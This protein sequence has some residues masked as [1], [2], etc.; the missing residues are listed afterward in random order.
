MYDPGYEGEVVD[1][2]LY[3]RTDFLSEAELKHARA[4]YAAEVTLVDRQVGRLLEKIEDLGLLANTLVMLTTDHGFL[5]GEHGIIG[6]SLISGDGM[7]YIPLYEEISHIPLIAHFPGAGPGAP[8]AI[9][10]PMDFMPTL[11]DLAGIEAPETVHGAS[12]APVLRGES[13]GHREFSVSSPHLDADTCAASVRCGKWSGTF[14]SETREREGRPDRAVDGFAKGA[15][16]DFEREDLLFDLGEDPGQ[17][18]NLAARHP[19]VLAE[20]RRKAVGFWRE[21][22]TAPAILERW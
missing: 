15:G 11:L 17:Q 22:G 1:Y 7:A 12:F 16:V 13:E 2:P 9:V 6:K 5:H 19:D 10:Q 8:E 14:W 3:A 21:I 20:L 4:L 18:K